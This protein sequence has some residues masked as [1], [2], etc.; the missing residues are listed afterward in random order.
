MMMM[1]MMMS[2]RMM[3][4]MV[5][6][7]MYGVLRGVVPTVTM[8]TAVIQSSLFTMMSGIGPRMLHRRT[9]L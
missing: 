8:V 7:A 1:M 9:K 5:R 2:R 3:G 4:D 6:G